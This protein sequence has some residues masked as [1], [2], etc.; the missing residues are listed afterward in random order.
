MIKELVEKYQKVSEEL[1]K[2]TGVIIFPGKLHCEIQ[3]LVKLAEKY[4]SKL[5]VVSEEYV[6]E[7]PYYIQ[8]VIQG[9]KFFALCN[10]ESFKKFVKEKVA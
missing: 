5:V 10:N 6:S 7:Y 4:K 2:S 3:D 9:Y 8:T 1:A